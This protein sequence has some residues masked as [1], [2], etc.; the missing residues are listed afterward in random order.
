MR[1]DEPITSGTTPNGR[2]LNVKRLAGDESAFVS[3]PPPTCGRAR[4]DVLLLMIGELRPVEGRGCLNFRFAELST[5]E[6]F[7]SKVL[8]AELSRG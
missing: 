7:A 8:F 5:R 1:L 6:P 3:G 2:K 4:V